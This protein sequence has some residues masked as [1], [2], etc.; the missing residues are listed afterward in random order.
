ME[1]TSKEVYEYVSKK[2]ND[3]VIER[4]NCRMSWQEFPIYKSDLDFYDRISPSFEVDESYLKEFFEKNSDLKDHFEYKDWKLKAKISTPTLCP[5]ERERRRFSFMNNQYLYKRKIDNTGKQWIS[6]FSPD[7]P[8]KVYDFDYRFSRDREYEKVEN[9]N[10]KFN[11]NLSYLLDNTPVAYK[12]WRWHF[13]NSDYCNAVVN[14]KDSYMCFYGIWL[15]DC[16]YVYDG[17]S[18]DTSCVD[19]DTINMCSFCYDC[20][21]LKNCSAMLHCRNCVNCNNSSYLEN[22]IWCHDCYNCINLVNQSYCINNK[23]Y[24]KEEYQKIIIDIK[25]ESKPEQEKVM[26]CSQTECENS[27]GNNYTWC[28]NCS[29]SNA[30]TNCENTRYS[31]DIPDMKNVYDGRWISS[32]FGLETRWSGYTHHCLFVLAVLHSSDVLYSQRCDNCDHLFWCV[33]LKDK[34][35]CIYNKEYTKEEYNKIVP[36]IIAQMMRDNEWWEF[37]DPKFSYF[38]YNESASMEMYPLT[39]DEAL[40]MWYHWRDYE[41]PFPKVEKYVPWEKLPKVWCKMIQEKKPDF[42]EKILNYAIV[43]E[44]SKKPFR[45]TKQEIDFYIKHDIP[46]PTKHPEVRHQERFAKKDGSIMHLVHCDECG[47]EMLSV[48]IS[49]QWKKILCEKCFYKEL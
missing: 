5:E 49:W 42:L 33:W 47:E 12:S 7:K 15:E 9:W 22:C 30:L 41:A 24:T 39:K 32:E 26:W 11:E 36:Q 2:A 46:L 34:S 8:Y 48:H 29:F 4:K 31:R 6:V 25:P 19:C 38:W 3:P 44:V 1:Y 21:Q 17:I 27:F 23:Q 37:F 35:Y 18:N 40:N 13:E 28:K 16:M 20:I 45:L 10:K 43:C 14:A